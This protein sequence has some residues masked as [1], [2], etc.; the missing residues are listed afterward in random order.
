MSQV[1]GSPRKEMRAHVSR[2]KH[3][4]MH[5]TEAC[6]C[7]Q[8]YKRLFQVLEVLVPWGLLC[9]WSW[10]RGTKY[11]MLA[12]MGRNRNDIERIIVTN[13]DGGNQRNPTFRVLPL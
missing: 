13:N 8:L 5:K 12:K 11:H 7:D 4:T 9:V 1:K 3:V 6:S 2:R 10:R